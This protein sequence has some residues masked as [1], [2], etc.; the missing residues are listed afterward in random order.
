MTNTNQKMWNVRRNEIELTWDYGT[1]DTSKPCATPALEAWRLFQS[2]YC[3]YFSNGVLPNHKRLV[4]L[5]KK[6]GIT[7]F[8]YARKSLA[9][10]MESIGGLLLDAAVAEINEIKFKAA[11]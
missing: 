6:A 10:D 7:E 8:S 1:F 5:A 4:R 2:M 3:N 9:L 11:A